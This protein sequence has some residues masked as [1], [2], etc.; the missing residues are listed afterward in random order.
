[1][2]R[3]ALLLCVTLTGCFHHVVDYCTGCQI[4]DSRRLAPR[5]PTVPRN[6][7]AVVILVHGAFGFGDEWAPLVTAL[8][9]A[10]E[11]HFV[12]FSWHGPWTRP[13]LAAHALTGL[14]QA[15]LDSA[16]SSVQQVLIISHSAGGL[17][18][19]YAVRHA[20]VPDGRHL[21]LA[22]VA[23]FNL[24]VR[25]DVDYER[26]INTP[27]G[28][29]VGGT[30][31]PAGNVPAGAEIVEYLTED[32]HPLAPNVLEGRA[33]FLGNHAGHNRALGRVGVPL[34]A[35]ARDGAPPLGAVI[36]P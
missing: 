19:S 21:S 4:V 34:I 36:P 10:P 3:A 7:R 22:K 24:P 5:P 9:A 32:E 31:K 17:I 15:Y 35:A 28:Y 27:L 11:I 12:A 26:R 33:V 14:T 30:A 16:P 29:A 6:K 1:V 25:L 23:G 8:R 20:R 13:D 2:L 18:A